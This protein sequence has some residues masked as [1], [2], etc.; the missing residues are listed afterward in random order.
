MCVLQ[1]RRSLEVQGELLKTFY[2]TD[3]IGLGQQ[4][5]CW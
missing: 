5:L 2:D 1:I 4:Y 3:G